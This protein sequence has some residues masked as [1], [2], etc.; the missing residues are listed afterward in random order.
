MNIEQQN[1]LASGGPAEGRWRLGRI[2]AGAGKGGATMNP[3]LKRCCVMMDRGED[4]RWAVI[5]NNETLMLLL[6][7]AESDGQREGG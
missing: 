4:D 3:L 6:V 5:Y 7:C 1:G 2:F